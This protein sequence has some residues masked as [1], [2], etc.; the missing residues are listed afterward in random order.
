MS[1]VDRRAF[2]GL[3]G[4]ALA[5]GLLAACSSDGSRSGGATSTTTRPAPT[6]SSSTTTATASGGQVA[7]LTV[8]DFEAIGTC[9]LLPEKTAGP[10]PLDRQLD[11]RDITEGHGKGHEGNAN[12]TRWK[13]C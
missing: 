11:R 9:R 10:F 7:A 4:G 1:D 12:C 2:I 6:R 5:A 3:G 8:A 13:E